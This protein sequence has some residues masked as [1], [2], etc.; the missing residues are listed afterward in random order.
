[1]LSSCNTVH[2]VGKSLLYRLGGKIKQWH[3]GDMGPW[4]F[5]KPL[6]I[7]PCIISRLRVFNVEFFSLI[8]VKLLGGY[9]TLYRVSA[10]TYRTW[11]VIENATEPNPYHK[12]LSP[13]NHDIISADKIF[14][15]S[16]TFRSHQICRQWVACL[17]NTTVIVTSLRIR[18]CVARRRKLPP[19]LQSNI[20]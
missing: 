4:E 20:D 9:V 6:Q 12:Y 15:H 8:F 16:S 2:Y 10:F 14:L 17:M 1:M 13:P 7:Q 3:V 18:Q 11:S 19:I 5:W